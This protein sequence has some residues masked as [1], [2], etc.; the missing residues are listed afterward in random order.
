V[1]YPT[2][3]HDLITIEYKGEQSSPITSEKIEAVR[4]NKIGKAPGMDIARHFGNV[5]KLSKD[6]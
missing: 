5:E 3:S 4:I 1:G 6:S 2:K